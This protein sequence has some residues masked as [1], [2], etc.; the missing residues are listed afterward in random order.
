MGQAAG[1]DEKSGQ[2]KTGEGWIESR[3]R[4]WGKGGR[5]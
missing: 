4:R 3:G 1:A 2:G 5:N